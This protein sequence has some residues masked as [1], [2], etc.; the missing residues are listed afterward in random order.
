MGEVILYFDK[1]WQPRFIHLSLPTKRYQSRLF[2]DYSYGKEF[3]VIRDVPDWVW[4]KIFAKEY[5]EAR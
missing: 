2:Y 5:K 3:K 4:V 1:D